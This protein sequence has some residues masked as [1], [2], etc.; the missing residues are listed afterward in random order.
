MNA[1]EDLLGN[2][3]F[4]SSKANSSPKTIG[5]MKKKQMAEEMDPEKLKVLYML[6][7]IIFL[8]VLKSVN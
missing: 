1:F 4:T 8:S 3:Q 2:H 7:P 5:D 6:T